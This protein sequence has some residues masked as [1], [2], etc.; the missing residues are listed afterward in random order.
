MSTRTLAASAAH[1]KAND[2]AAVPLLSA[3][4]CLTSGYTVIAHLRRG[5]DLDVYDVWS[6]ERGCRCVAKVPRPDRLAH[7]A[8]RQR[9]IREG[10]LL[11]RLTHPHIVRAYETLTEP[12][13]IVI[14]ETLTGATLKHLITSRDRR[15]PLTAVA[16]LGLHVCAAL[17]YLHHQG[18]VHL[19]LKPSNIVSDRGLAKVLD[20]SIA[21]PPG[22]GSRGIGTPQY[23]AP[24]QV[25]GGLLSA[26]TD[27]WGLG[28]VLFEA[29]TGRQPFAAADADAT[30]TRYAQL[31]RRVES[32]RCHRRV[33][34]LFATAI[35]QCLDPEP[36]RRPTVDELCTL[37]NRLV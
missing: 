16:Y 23:M 27:V 28:L 12:S 20:L 32:V 35:A 30:E 33:P 14:L 29:A 36:A 24:E 1:E 17:H 8:T 7:R 4:T 37:L 25:R 6:Q 21:R 5:H 34:A 19:D 18:I 10:R 22:R 13:P 31:E 11:E 2:E 9:L 3:G 26:A 15:L